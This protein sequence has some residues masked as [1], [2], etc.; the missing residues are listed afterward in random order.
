MKS[1]LLHA[2]QP[3]FGGVLSDDQAVSISFNGFD[4]KMEDLGSDFVG[5]ANVWTVALW[6]KPFSAAT[7]RS[8]IFAMS[9]EIT[10]VR[11]TIG[12]IQRGDLAGDFLQIATYDNANVLFKNYKYDNLLTDDV[13]QHVLITW[14]GTTLILYKDADAKTASLKSKDLAGTMD[15]ATARRVRIGVNTIWSAQ[16]YDGLIHSAAVWN[17][18]LPT[19]E[20]IQVYNGGVGINLDGDVGD[21]SSSANLLHWWRLGFDSLD[22]GKDYGV[23][24]NLFDV[25]DDAANITAGDDIIA[26]GLG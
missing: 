18:A 7:D 4:E 20:I 11:N 5:I 3:T 10:N 2:T 12:I 26:G 6:L 16:Y 23:H 13:W 24:T 8:R 1:I 22:M 9:L 17:V 21:Y 15:D 14:D 19:A 25:M